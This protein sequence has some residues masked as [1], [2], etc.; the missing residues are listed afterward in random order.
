M[1]RK[2]DC[3]KETLLRIAERAEQ[4]MKTHGTLLPEVAQAL[5][6]EEYAR[7]LIRT[8]TNVIFPENKK[9]AQS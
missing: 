2:E 3:D 8:G 1:I 4:I 7:Q 5:I 9:A 6:E